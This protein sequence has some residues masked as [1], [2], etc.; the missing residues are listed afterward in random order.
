MI[1]IMI[2]IPITNIFAVKIARR[3]TTSWPWNNGETSLTLIKRGIMQRYIVSYGFYWNS[4]NFVLFKIDWLY[5]LN[6]MFGRVYLI[7][8]ESDEIIIYKR[9]YFHKLSRILKATPNDVIGNVWW[10]FFALLWNYCN[11]SFKKC[12]VDYI[13]LRFITKTIGYVEE[14]YVPSV[15]PAMKG[16]VFKI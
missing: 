6:E 11:K 7:V 8:D 2:S 14:E 10:N 3:S 9:S 1:L 12:S 5:I 13:H 15:L 16:Y 4:K